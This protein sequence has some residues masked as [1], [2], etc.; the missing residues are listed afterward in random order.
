MADTVSVEY[1]YPPNLLDEIIDNRAGN[2]KVIVRLS[3]T[4]DGSGETNALK[5]DLSDLKT[6]NGNNPTKTAIEWI[7]YHI[8]GLTCLLEWERTPHAEIIRLNPNA[9]VAEGKFD[10]TSFGGKVDPGEDD[11]TG[12]ILLTTTNADSGDNYEIIMCIR[13]KD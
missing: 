1:L 12:D 9:M 3:G 5:V 10:W 6:H 11:L 13:L 7:E 4:S 8:F 2:R